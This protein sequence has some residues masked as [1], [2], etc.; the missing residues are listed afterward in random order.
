MTVT[1]PSPSDA[2]VRRGMAAR[3]VLVVDDSRTNLNVIGRRLGRLGYMTALCDN[4]GEA[5]DRIAAGGFDLV[6]LDLV[7]P[8]LSGLQV[9]AELRTRPETA[10]LPVIVV[11]GRSDP[12]AAIEALATGADDHVAKPFDF[13]VLAAR[14][15]RT[16][17]RAKRMADL[18]RSN[19]ALDAR[20]AARAIELGET[21]AELA[22]MVAERQ[23]MADSLMVL[24]EEI[25]RLRA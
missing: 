1:L 16:L 11:T 6:L 24:N 25:A 15:E 7:M 23:R 20:I 8:G 21:R 17:T 12:A 4:G 10:D 14:I 9:L 19:A 18:K 2:P 5:L 22:G 3:T 13:D